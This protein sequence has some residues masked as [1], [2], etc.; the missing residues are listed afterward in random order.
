LWPADAADYKNKTDGRAIHSTAGERTGKSVT[1][2][3][4]YKVIFKKKVNYQVKD[5][6]AHSF[7]SKRC[8][9]EPVFTPTP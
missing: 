3:H 4:H 1:P 7:F 5:F 8:S 9:L 2:A 6:S